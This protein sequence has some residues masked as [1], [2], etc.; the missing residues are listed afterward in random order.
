MAIAEAPLRVPVRVSESS[1]EIPAFDTTPQSESRDMTNED[2]N[3][4]LAKRPPVI[5]REIGTVVRMIV[6]LDNEGNILD[7]FG[8]TAFGV[9]KADALTKAK[10]L[11]TGMVD[12]S[13]GTLT[14]SSFRI[15]NPDGVTPKRDI[16]VNF[17]HIDGTGV[18]IASIEVYEKAKA[19]GLVG[20][21]DLRAAYARGKANGNH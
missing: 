15:V 3:L 2:F 12:A 20:T 6:K 4:L 8:A 10:K 11:V 21:S 13:N 9:S 1:Q 16:P 19:H 14:T 5:Q 18:V 7:N 17:P